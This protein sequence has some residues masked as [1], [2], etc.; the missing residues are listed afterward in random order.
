MCSGG[1]EH[2]TQATKNGP[3]L[4][5]LKA[6]RFD[7]HVSRNTSC[8]RLTR[9]G[10]YSNGLNHSEL[11]FLQPLAKAWHWYENAKLELTAGRV[12]TGT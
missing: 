3:Y 12:D 7:Y 2:P 11:L 1:H 5:I 10:K 4:C 8:W 9:L 6:F